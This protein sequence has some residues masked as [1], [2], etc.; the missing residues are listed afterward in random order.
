VIHQGERLRWRNADTEKHDVVADTPSL[1]ESVTTGTLA[2]GD[3]RLFPMNTIGTTRIHC[4][5]HPQMV[6]L[7]VVQAR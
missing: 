2:P 1:P 3:E 4:T 5:I 7:L 6:G